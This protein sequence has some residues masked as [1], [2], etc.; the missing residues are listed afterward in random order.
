MQIKVSE[1]SEKRLEVLLRESLPGHL[2]ARRPP[3]SSL[4]HHTTM[5]T[6]QRGT[7]E[8]PLCATPTSE[9]AQSS[10]GSPSDANIN[11]PG[12]TPSQGSEQ[13]PL[14]DPFYHQYQGP[15]INTGPHLT[16]VLQ[17][18]PHYTTA[19][20]SAYTWQSDSMESGYQTLYSPQI[21]PGRPGGYFPDQATE[22]LHASMAQIIAEVK[23]LGTRIAS[24]EKNGEHC[25]STNPLLTRI[26]GLEA[27]IK[28]LGLGSTREVRTRDKGL[29]RPSGSS[30]GVCNEHPLLKVCLDTISSLVSVLKTSALGAH[31]VLSNVRCG[32]VCKQ[33]K[34][35]QRSVC[36]G[37]AGKG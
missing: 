25:E 5:Y 8:T 28:E 24:L 11:R 2:Y 15:A 30:R 9:Y 34:T 18:V 33:G 7:S 26:E 36:G 1:L 27:Q 23:S 3:P 20:D 4:S 32:G 10:H 17:N 12:S 29:T 31:Y 19:T 22:S 14:F 16:Q 35:Y 6:P 21:R 13:Q 37:S